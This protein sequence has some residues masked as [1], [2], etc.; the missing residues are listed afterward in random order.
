MRRDL[1]ILLGLLLASGGCIPDQVHGDDDGS[2]DDDDGSGDDDDVY[3]PCEEHADCSDGLVCDRPHQYCVECRVTEDCDELQRCD[4]DRCVEATPCGSDL[5]CTAEGLVCDTAA[6]RCVDCNSASDCSELPCLFHTCFS[7]HDCES[8]TDCTDLSMVCEDAPTP[9]WPESFDGMGCQ[10]CGAP[11]DCG[12]R[13]NCQDGLCFD[14]CG[15]RVCGAFQGADCGECPGGGQ[16]ASTGMAC[17][18]TVV[19]GIDFMP[20]RI[21][22]DDDY[23]FASDHSGGRAYCYDIDS[24]EQ[25]YSVGAGEDLE[26]IAINSTHLFWADGDGPIR[27]IPKEGGSTETI[28]DEDGKCFEIVADDTWLLCSWY[29]LAGSWEDNGIWEVPV[30]GGYFDRIFGGCNFDSLVLVDD[31][32]FWSC[33]NN[34]IL[35]KIQVGTPGADYEVLV[36][37]IQVM[38]LIVQEDHVYYPEGGTWRVPVDGGSP[39]QVHASETTPL[40][41]HDGKL[42]YESYSGALMTMEP[43]GGHEQVVLSEADADGMSRVVLG[44]DGAIWIGFQGRIVKLTM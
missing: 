43:A 37:D 1:A 13:E 17:M 27:R 35:G 32:I 14:V 24:G 23:L 39:Q 3:A 12:A 11:A 10:E 9:Q 33:F 7:T 2:G 28:A 26:D 8:S 20:S 15:D 29:T 19:S 5:D 42:F 38:H 22:V 40:F 16:C 31:D 30:D 4:G 18:Q 36:D 25:Q 21:E 44:P 6:G 34:Q 41:I